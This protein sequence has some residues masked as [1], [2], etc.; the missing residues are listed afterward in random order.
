MT[1]PPAQGPR[2]GSEPR[3]PPNRAAA[4]GRRPIRERAA[5]DALWLYGLHT[6]ELALKN[7]ERRALKL[8][9]TR[10]AKMRLAERFPDGLPLDPEE[11]SPYE[12]DRLLGSDAV[13]Q[14]VAL[15]VEPLA[16]AAD[17]KRL[18]A[19]RLV[20][21]LD[22]VTDPHNVGAILRSAAA[23]GVDAVVTTT[24]HSPAESG[25]LAKSASG[26]LDI[27]PLLTVRN[28]GDAVAELKE[29]GFQVVGLDS[30]G[31]VPLE[32]V[33]MT[34]PVVLI[35]GAEGHGLRQRTRELSDVVARLEMPGAIKSLNVSNAAALSLYIAHR[36]LG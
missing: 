13:H 14:G 36:A 2:A 16:F 21:M 10:N 32:D 3:R 7:P 24:R 15:E 33:V 8:L 1:K 18:S 12:L 34:A 35:L 19:A 25:V 4:A 11:A 5:G 29:R 9:A 17:L 22:Q 20:L 31:P 23:L 28:L 27:V 6:V 26:A 30:D